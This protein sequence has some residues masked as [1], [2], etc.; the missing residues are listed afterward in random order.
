MGAT[1]TYLILSFSRHLRTWTTWPT[2]SWRFPRHEAT[3]GKEFPAKIFKTFHRRRRHPRPTGSSTRRS[4]PSS[5]LPTSKT[6]WA[7]TILHRAIAESF[8]TLKIRCRQPVVQIPTHLR[9][10]TSLKKNHLRGPRCYQPTS[11]KARYNFDNRPPTVD[12]NLSLQI[13]G[14]PP[15]F[16]IASAL[17][18]QRVIC[19]KIKTVESDD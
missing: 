11:K 19:L 7:D 1:Y 14:W 12:I 3:P 5:H 8:S 2:R 17:K 16:M 18:R 10:D 6:V 13:V 15:T 9:C 4:I